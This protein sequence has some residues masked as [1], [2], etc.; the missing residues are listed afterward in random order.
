MRLSPELAEEVQNTL[1]DVLFSLAKLAE[2]EVEDICFL[3]LIPFIAAVTA[4]HC[5]ILLLRLR[6]HLF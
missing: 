4:V 3:P 2:S 5:E 1:N 6:C